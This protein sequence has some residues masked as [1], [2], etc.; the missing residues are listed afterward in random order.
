MELHLRVDC[1]PAGV[2]VGVLVMAM[3]F[4]AAKDDGGRGV[5]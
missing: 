2:Y 1:I 3:M 4:V 5:A